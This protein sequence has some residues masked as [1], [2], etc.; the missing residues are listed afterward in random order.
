M[1]FPPDETAELAQ[2]RAEI[3][4]YRSTALMNDRERA[5]FLGL[6]DG[7]RIRENAKILHPDN[8]VC[9]TNVWIGE[10]AV[11]DAQG[12]LEIGDNTQIGLSVF[13]W[14][15]TT[16]MQAV[17]GETGRDKGRIEYRPTKIGSNCFIGG[18]SVIAPGVTIGDQAIISPLSFV[19]NDVPRRG[20]VS[21]RA[22]R[23][24]D[25]DR[26]AGLETELAALRDRLTRI[27]GER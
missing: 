15:H 13:V 23:R 4:R 18:P 24:I 5:R 20:V 26:I 8:L 2:I 10:G 22:Q 1:Y 6:P 7:C 25:D 3:L 12:G 9:G 14:S 17:A 19:E 11:L 16:H 27:E 21:S